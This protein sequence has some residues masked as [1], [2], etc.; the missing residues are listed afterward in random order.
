LHQNYPNPFNPTTT[1]SYQ[2]PVSSNVELTIYSM[3]G[4]MV[5]RLVSEQQA[6]G[7]YQ[8]EWDAGDMASGVYF[9]RIMAGQQ[10]VQM[11]K[12]ILLK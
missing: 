6:E 1:I 12:L 3:A 7:R 11:K 8:Y 5:T 9:Y 10:F 2:L 4:Q